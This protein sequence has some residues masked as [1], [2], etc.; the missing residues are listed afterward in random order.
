MPHCDPAV[1]R[2]AFDPADFEQMFDEKPAQRC[3]LAT[4][5]SL[6]LPLLPARSLSLVP[7]RVPQYLNQ[8][9]VEDSVEKA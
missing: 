4:C 9:S 8:D 6:A 1:L 2:I 7:S 3:P 5:S